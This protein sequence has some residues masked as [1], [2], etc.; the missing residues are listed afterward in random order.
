M[1]SLF[2]RVFP[3]I[4]KR[5]G[6]E[7]TVE[8]RTPLQPQAHEAKDPILEA[9][10]SAIINNNSNNPNNNNNNKPLHTYEY[11]EELNAFAAHLVKHKYDRPS[12]RDTI[13]PAP[14]L[15]L[16]EELKM[17]EEKVMGN[18]NTMWAYGVG[19]ASLGFLLASLLMR[20]HVEPLTSLIFTSF[21]GIGGY[22]GAKL[23]QHGLLPPLSFLPPPPPPLPAPR[24][25][26]HAP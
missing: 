9:L 10:R 22:T 25:R 3:R 4:S 6:A 26:P 8:T 2:D 24:R 14:E 1:S 17:K 20:R 7:T 15:N 16:E 5:G 21:A 23:D 18:P 19:G 12:H 13:L 11:E